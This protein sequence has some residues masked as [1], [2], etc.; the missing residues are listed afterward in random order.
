MA[1]KSN[2][3]CKYQYVVYKDGLPVCVGNREE[4]MAFTGL[5]E[6]SFYANVTRTRNGQYLGNTYM[7]YKLED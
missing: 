2:K 1:E 7:I 6:S 5:K 3:A 4:C